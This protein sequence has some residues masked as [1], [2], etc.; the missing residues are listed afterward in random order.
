[1]LGIVRV[2]EGREVDVREEAREPFPSGTSVTVSCPACRED[3][4]LLE[5][6]DLL[7]AEIVHVPGLTKLL[8]LERLLPMLQK[9]V[10]LREIVRRRWCE[11]YLI[12]LVED[13]MIRVAIHC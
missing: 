3:G 6:I 11:R 12:Q 2:E 10:L 4:Y 7:H 5:S 9:R 13:E 8:L 1:M